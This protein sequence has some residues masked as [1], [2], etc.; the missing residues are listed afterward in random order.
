MRGRYKPRVPFKFKLFVKFPVLFQFL[1][2]D[3]SL[4]PALVATSATDKEA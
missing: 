3:K 4:K 1:M 2:C